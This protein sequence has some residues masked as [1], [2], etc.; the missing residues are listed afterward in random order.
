MTRTESVRH[1]DGHRITDVNGED[2]LLRADR[3]LT[4]QE[5]KETIETL[6]DRLD[7]PKRSRNAAHRFIATAQQRAAALGA[8]VRHPSLADSARVLI[9][10][11]ARAGYL[12]LRAAR[13]QP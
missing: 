4:R 8:R 9:P 12:L 2:E 13:R 6:A 10:L 1:P 5:L 7:V 3:E 11:A